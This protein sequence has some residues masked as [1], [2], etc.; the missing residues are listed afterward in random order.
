M[1]RKKV[2]VLLILFVVATASIV[3]LKNNL[4]FSNDNSINVAYYYALRNSP[5]YE[6]INTILNLPDYDFN[7]LL[8]PF[9]D[10]FYA[11]NNKF[12][13]QTSFNNDLLCNENRFMLASAIATFSPECYKQLLIDMHIFVYRSKIST[14]MFSKIRDYAIDYYYTRNILTFNE[15][16]RV[17]ATINQLNLYVLSHLFEVGLTVPQFIQHVITDEFDIYKLDNNLL[18]FMSIVTESEGAFDATSIINWQITHNVNAVNKVLTT[19]LILE[20]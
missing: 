12:D 1:K 9:R 8:I 20:D 13:I 2:F 18:I 4:S 6:L 7:Y 14:E 11:F 16:H 10:A 3:L 17:I 5:N 19:P 15:F